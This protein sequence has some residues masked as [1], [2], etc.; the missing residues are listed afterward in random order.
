MKKSSSFC[1]DNESYAF[2]ETRAPIITISVADS[3]IG[4]EKSKDT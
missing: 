3:E 2:C 1:R 4:T